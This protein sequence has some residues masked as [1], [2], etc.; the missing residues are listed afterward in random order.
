MI[1]PPVVTVMA[2]LA[3]WVVPPPVPVIVRP[4]A[5]VAVAAPAVRVR[6]EEPEPGAA[7]DAGLKLALA[8]EGSPETNSETAE[9]KL[10]LMVVETPVVCEL[11][12]GMLKALLDAAIVKSLVG[13]KI[14]S[15]M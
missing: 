2:I 7:I 5:P 8:P 11:P 4:Y 10:P 9:L 1:P 6:V 14:T 3:V 15:I 13:L 12:C